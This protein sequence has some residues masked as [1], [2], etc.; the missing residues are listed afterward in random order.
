MRFSIFG[1]SFVLLAPAISNHVH[2]QN[3]PAKSVRIV[4]PVPPGGGLD[5][6]ARL[7]GRKLQESFGQTFVIENRPGAAT[8]LGTELVARAPGDGYT[9]LSAPS[10]LASSVT[11]FRKLSFDIQKDL[12]AVSQFSSAAQFL[13]VHPSLPAKSVKE[14]VAIAKAQAGKLNAGS[15]GNGGANHFALEML[16]QRAGIQATHIPYK[17][18]GPATIALM[19]GEVDF[20]FAGSVTTMPHLRSGKV[21]ALAVTTI[22]PSRAAPEIPTL[23]SLY[24]GFES[25]NWYAMFAPATTPGSIVNRLGAEIAAAVKSPE[26]RDFM[27]K[28]GAE[29]VGSTTPEFAAYFRKEVERYAQVIRTAN[30]RIE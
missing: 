10:T 1:L 6:Q 12:T 13:L 15:S 21:R 27:L 5:P 24:P 26:V 29:P 14:F 22:T 17:G 11:L 28:E 23:H 16:K 20:S 8:M 30:I 3:Y 18:S 9:L 7:I 25:N 4:V 2:A 19:S